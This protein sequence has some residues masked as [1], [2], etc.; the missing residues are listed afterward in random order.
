[1]A[2]QVMNAVENLGEVLHG[3]VIHNSPYDLFFGTSALKV[4]RT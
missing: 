3:S 4:R 1:V 2:A